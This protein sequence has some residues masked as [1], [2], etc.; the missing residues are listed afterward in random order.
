M[1]LFKVNYAV[2]R[3]SP[4]KHYVF[5]LFYCSCFSS[6][7]NSQS[8]WA[9]AYHCRLFNCTF[10][11]NFLLS[12]VSSAVSTVSYVSALSFYVIIVS[13][14][15]KAVAVQRY[16]VCCVPDFGLIR[17]CIK[18]LQY[19]QFCAFDC[20]TCILKFLCIVHMSCLF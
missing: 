13:C 11:C 2:R 9:L 3:N 15:L 12:P 6:P 17:N 20:S 4:V 7:K 14:C 16:S 5:P 10:S 1:S 18:K 8:C 19:F